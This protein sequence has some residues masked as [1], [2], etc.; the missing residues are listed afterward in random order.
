[1]PV[2]ALAAALVLAACGG[3]GASP[4]AVVDGREITMEQLE[5]EVTTGLALSGAPA[6]RAATAEFSRLTLGFLIRMDVVQTFAAREGIGVS[7]EEVEATMDELVARFGSRE[8]FEQVLADRGVTEGEVRVNVERSLLLDAMM[9]AVSE[10][11]L[12]PPEDPDTGPQGSVNPIGVRAGERS[13]DQEAAFGRWLG[14]QLRIAEVE[15]N[16]RFGRLD[17]STG[18]VV[19]LT[20][21]ADLG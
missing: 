15:V 19:P 18:T 12:A 3:S 5:R 17:L 14:E 7:T 21:T 6:T 13:V 9:L 1:M 2:A 8:G 4:A 20:S 16:P 11:G 10:R